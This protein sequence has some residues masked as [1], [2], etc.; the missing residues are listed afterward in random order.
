MKL[1]PYSNGL[2]PVSDVS[3]QYE[4]SAAANYFVSEIR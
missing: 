1:N 4:L 3:L 2:I